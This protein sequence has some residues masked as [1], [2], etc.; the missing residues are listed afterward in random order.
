MPG[1]SAWPG[2]LAAM[3]HDERRALLNR[4]SLPDEDARET[5]AR[6]LTALRMSVVGQDEALRRL[7]LAATQSV[8]G[9]GRRV[10][11]LGEGAAFIART[12][13]RLTGPGA[14]HIPCAEFSESGWKGPNLPVYLDGRAMRAGQVVHLA[15]IEALAIRRGMYG[16]HTDGTAEQRTGKQHAIE[17]LMAGESVRVGDEGKLELATDQLLVIATARHLDLPERPG[18]DA[19]VDAGYTPRLAELFASA[20]LITLDPLSA[21]HV[22]HI[23]VDAVAD[24]CRDAEELGY[25]IDADPFALLRVA[26]AVVDG[27]GSVRE[28]QGWIRDMAERGILHLLDQSA[29]SDAGVT[30]TIALDDFQAPS[31]ARGR[32]VE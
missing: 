17:Q 4:L 32:W 18:A 23:L 7:A 19:W 31:A 5:Y 25:A 13:G 26:E 3:T 2:N 16:G 24:A 6:T 12:L 20:M 21:D 27:R 15:G 28:A 11:L 1:L 30:W 22:W 14:V 10:V 9:R 8:R 29:P